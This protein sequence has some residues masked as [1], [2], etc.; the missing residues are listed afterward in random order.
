[1]S[2]FFRDP[3]VFAAVRGAISSVPG[4]SG[5]LRVWC[6]GCATGEEA[7]SIAIL[8]SDVLP[9]DVLSK[10]VVFATDIDAD[11]LDQARIAEHRDDSLGNMDADCMAK[12][13]FM[14]SNVFWKVGYTTRNL[15]RFGVLDI[16][17]KHPISKVHI[18]F[19]RNLFI[20][21][22]KEL[23]AEVFRKLDFAIRPG[24]LLVLG[25]AEQVPPEWS[26]CYRP[27]GRDLNVFQKKV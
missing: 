12:Y 1:M 10:T 16:V 18:L 3:E 7:Y 17:K 2:E 15:V 20:Y 19:C 6:C 25:M 5:G 27:V 11:A 24:G 14:S 22:N 9:P 8:L 26:H 23:Q 21:F 4:A 13:M